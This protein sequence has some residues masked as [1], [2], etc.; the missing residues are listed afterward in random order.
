MKANLKNPITRAELD[1]MLSIYAIKL[2]GMKHA[3]EK[4][5]TYPDVSNKLGDLA[6]YIQ[7]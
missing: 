7:E 6:F 5:V 1:K 3:T 4:S 2:L